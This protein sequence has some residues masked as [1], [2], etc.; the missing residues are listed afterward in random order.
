MDILVLVELTSVVLKEVAAP[1]EFTEVTV[2]SSGVVVPFEIEKLRLKLFETGIAPDVAAAEAGDTTGG[3][4][5][6]LVLL[7]SVASVVVAV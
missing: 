6:L 2:W 1:V 7:V 3:E 4:T 5:L